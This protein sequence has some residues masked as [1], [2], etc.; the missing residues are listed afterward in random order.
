M[1]GGPTHTSLQLDLCI[2]KVILF[3]FSYKEEIREILERERERERILKNE[4]GLHSY[5][6]ILRSKL[7][8]S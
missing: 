8:N 3:L 1:V 7:Y 6:I 4:L 5:F 2:F